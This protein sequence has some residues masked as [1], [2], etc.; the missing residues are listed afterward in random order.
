MIGAAIVRA[1]N[2]D[3]FIQDL[4]SKLAFIS[5]AFL[6]SLPTDGSVVRTDNTLIIEGIILQK[7]LD[8]L[9]S[10]HSTFLLISLKF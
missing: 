2:N 9:K 8:K 10:S 7:E 4:F 6:R 3:D 1:N 5:L